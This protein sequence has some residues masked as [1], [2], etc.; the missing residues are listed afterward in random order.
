MANVGKMFWYSKLECWYCKID[1]RK[2]WL[3]PDEKDA[4]QLYIQHLAKHGRVKAPTVSELVAIYL[5]AIEL[6]ANTVE[7]K[8][9]ILDTLVEKYGTMKAAELEPDHVAEWMLQVYPKAGPTTR[10]DRISEVQAAWR[11]GVLHGLLPTS[12]IGAIKKPAPGQ[13]EHYIPQTEWVRY[14]KACKNRALRDVFEFMLWTGARPQE[15]VILHSDW[16]LGDR[17][18]VPKGLAKGRRKA[19]MILVPTCIR[20]GVEARVADGGIVFRTTRGT[21]WTK[22]SI[23]CS[24]RRLKVRLADE[25]LCATSARA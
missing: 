16:W 6:Q 18:I 20:K 1:G 22:N 21:A 2:Q 24:F 7:K 19:R 4:T 8:R 13:R 3:S 17:F 23:N 12:R 14:L 15:A 11:H 10:R 25:K 9:R 5:G